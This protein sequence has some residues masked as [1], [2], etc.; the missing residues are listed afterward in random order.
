MKTFWIY[1]LLSFYTFLSVGF[2][3]SI[4]ICH[5]RIS[6]FEV[7]A[8]EDNSCCSSKKCG[9]CHNVKIVIKKV[10]DEVQNTNEVL[11]VITK[12]VPQQFDFKQLFNLINCNAPLKKNLP[13]PPILNTYPSIHL[14]NCVFII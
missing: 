3:G 11:T 9:C 2:T 6:T 1:L 12:L 4:S 5:G 13:L 7:Y 14:K 10:V 8:L